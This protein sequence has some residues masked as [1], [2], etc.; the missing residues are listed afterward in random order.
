VDLTVE[1]E[2]QSLHVGASLCATTPGRL[3][4][5]EFVHPPWPGFWEAVTSNTR[6]V[7]LSSVNYTSGFRAPLEDIAPRL[8]ERGVLLYVDGTQSVGALRMDVGALEP[9]MMSVDAYKWM[10]TPNGAGF[11]Y[12]R[13]DVREWLRPHC[14][15][16]RSDRDWRRVTSLHHGAPRFSHLAE[17]YEGGMLPFAM[18]YAMDSVVEAMLA[19][20]TDAIERRVL[21]LAADLSGR[22]ERMGGAILHRGSQIVAARF[23]GRDAVALARGQ[24]ERKVLVSARHGNLRVSVHL[25]NH[26]EDLDRLESALAG[27]LQ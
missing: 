25:Y 27:S 6:L 19:F 20:G 2:S 8:R 4:G 26:E 21:Q 3:K 11:A 1:L 5:V 24:R 12:V 9:A 23:E 14:V 13:P 18:L 15:G 22:L 7:V 16:W 10:L 17:K